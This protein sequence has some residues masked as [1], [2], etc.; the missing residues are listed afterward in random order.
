MHGALL[1]DSMAGESEA[2]AIRCQDFGRHPVEGLVLIRAFIEKFREPVTFS[3]LCRRHHS[4]YAGQD[5]G[6]PNEPAASCDQGEKG[7]DYW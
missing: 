5:V 1:K 2:S 6:K 4:C 7:S 3:D